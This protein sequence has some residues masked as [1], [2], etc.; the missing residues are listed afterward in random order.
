[1][2]TELSL[3]SSACYHVVNGFSDATL[4]SF[5]QTVEQ[6]P[7]LLAHS[8]VSF[9]SKLIA[10]IEAGLFG[11]IKEVLKNRIDPRV[12]LRFLKFWDLLIS[13]CSSIENLTLLF[14]DQATNALILYPFDFS[15]TEVLQGYITV[16][17]GIS[18]RLQEF[19]VGL[20]FTDDR[21]DCPL[22]SHS[23]PFIV[24]GDSVVVSGARLVI[25]NCC[26]VKAPP[27]QAFIT[28][29]AHRSPFVY[30]LEHLGA[31]DELEFVADLV[32]VAPLE[33]R[34]F[35]LGKLKEELLKSDIVLLAKAAAF[36]A[37]SRARPLLMQVISERIHTFP[38]TAPLTLGLLLFA[39]DRKLIL[40][41]WAIH[42]GLVA[43]QP[44]PGFASAATVA[45][46]HDL[47]EAIGDVLLKQPSVPLVA[48]ALR[49]LE[50]FSREVPSV[51]NQVRRNLVASIRNAP[52]TPIMELITGPPEPRQR[53]DIDHFVRA[54]GE[55]PAAD[56]TRQA[57]LQ[58]SEV[59]AAIGR[60]VGRHF[61]WFELESVA[62][63]GELR[64]FALANEQVVTLDGRGIR[65]G[66]ELPLR[67]VVVGREKQLVT[68]SMHPRIAR[69]VGPV[70]KTEFEFATV[71]AATEFQ[72]AVMEV[73][74]KMIDAML[75]RF[76]E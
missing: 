32:N 66:E 21:K 4:L 67:Q 19:D 6:I 57:I 20:L 18:M 47:L 33:L 63:E 49:V 44:I 56:G 41:D 17:K 65:A 46:T 3:F 55:E 25:L 1:M 76:L 23:V 69:G 74:R 16:L 10:I 24:S 15:S 40:L 31:A 22:Y 54:H 12:Q 14:T 2:D 53:C 29:R 70:E 60:W 30:L 37:N 75:D 7:L 45:R 27:L 58:L 59:L 38:L 71:A 72:E 50:K 34:D 13:T 39:L 35:M 5:I 8:S 43:M 48:L 42:H 9:H 11:A 73:Q 68:V 28:D 61:Q 36:I 52:V 26:L 51:V 62:D 64:T